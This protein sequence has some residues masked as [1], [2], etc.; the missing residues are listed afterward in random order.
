M[1]VTYE[2][3]ERPRVEALMLYLPPSNLRVYFVELNL[4]VAN[5]VEFLDVLKVIV[6]SGELASK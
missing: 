6:S 5:S 3:S 1:R 2:V 4:F